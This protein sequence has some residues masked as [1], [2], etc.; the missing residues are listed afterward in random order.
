MGLTEPLLRPKTTME[1]RVH[2]VH[3]RTDT[4]RVSPAPLT[5]TQRHH[6]HIDRVGR[7]VRSREQISRV[8][9]SVWLNARISTGQMDL[10]TEIHRVREEAIYAGGHR[11]PVVF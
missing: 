9:V 2:R 8:P 3:G 6:G 7:G 5:S 4:A 11:V 1:M 10:T